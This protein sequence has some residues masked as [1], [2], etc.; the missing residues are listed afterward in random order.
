MVEAYASA[1][2]IAVL[3]N[4]SAASYKDFRREQEHAAASVGVDLLPMAAATRPNE[5]AASFANI[6]Q[7]RAQAMLVINDVLFFV[8]RQRVI[9]FAAKA[10][11]P[12]M[13]CFTEDVEAGGLMAYAVNY[14][15]LY[16]R[17]PIFVDKIL[18]GARPGDIAIEQPTRYELQLNLKTAKAL[19]IKFAQSILLQ[20]TKMME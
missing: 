7:H 13:Y 17:V 9:E 5:L 1:K 6:I 3:A 16:I 15:D 19:G 18:K 14:R 2:R 8:H 12:V 4:P 20:A 11:L 10:R